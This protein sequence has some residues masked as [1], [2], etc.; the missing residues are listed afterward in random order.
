MTIG[1]TFVNF[2]YCELEGAWNRIDKESTNEREIFESQEDNAQINVRIFD[3]N[4]RKY[5]MKKGSRIVIAGNI[6]KFNKQD[7]AKQP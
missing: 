1:Q 3:Y 5:Y 4:K 7:F 6:L 2:A